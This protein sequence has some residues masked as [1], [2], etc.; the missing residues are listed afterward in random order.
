VDQQLS[1]TTK[2][3]Q[4]TPTVSRAGKDILIGQ[5]SDITNNVESLVVER[6]ES[7][8]SRLQSLK[9]MA[10]LENKAS[11]EKFAN[12]IEAIDS[13]LQETKKLEDLVARLERR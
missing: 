3:T 6:I 7:L 12:F 13:G 10:V 5:I 9:L 8:I 4:P 11:L 1:E 2:P